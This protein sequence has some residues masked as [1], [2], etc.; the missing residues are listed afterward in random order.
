MVVMLIKGRLPWRGS[1]VRD[2]A[3]LRYGQTRIDHTGRSGSG[4][5]AFSQPQQNSL[6]CVLS[7][8]LL[9]TDT[10]LLACSPL[11]HAMMS[12][13]H[14]WRQCRMVKRYSA[15]ATRGKSTEENNGLLAG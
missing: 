15:S 2:R 7:P 10:H 9:R 4:S 14:E 1:A 8:S 3:R 5:E 13:A 11:V 6:R 12:R